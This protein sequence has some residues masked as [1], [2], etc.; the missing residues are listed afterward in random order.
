MAKNEL[1]VKSY[2][3]QAAISARRIVKFGATENS[4][5]Q[6]AAP[7]DT[8]FGLSIELDAAAG[9]RVDVVLLGMGEVVYGGVVTRGALL[10]SD[11]TG[12]AVVAAPAVGINNRTI[13]IA[14]QAGVAGDIGSVLL[15]PD[16]IQG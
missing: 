4:V 11:A 9:E 8:M 14:V 7:A 5:L 13:G 16:S 6:A 12:K 10:T 15:G 1:L 2:T 3:A